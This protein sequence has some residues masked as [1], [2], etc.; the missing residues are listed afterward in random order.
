MH[1]L[2]LELNIPD[3]LL[4]KHRYDA[5]ED[6]WWWQDTVDNFAENTGQSINGLWLE[7]WEAELTTTPHHKR[8]YQVEFA[9]GRQGEYVYFPCSVR[10]LTTYITARGLEDRFPTLL[11]YHEHGQGSDI[12]FVT[13]HAHNSCNFY[14]EFTEYNTSWAWNGMDEATTE[15]MD[16]WL[17]AEA[18]AL[19]HVID[20][21][22][23]ALFDRLKADLEAEYD[24]LTSDEEVAYQLR[25]RYDLD[26]LF[27][28]IVDHGDI[29][30]F[31]A[32]HNPH[33]ETTHAAH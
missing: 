24:S 22:V 7:T 6:E 17:I 29:P 31:T 12:E 2:P 14:V 33:L 3:W 9:L 25:H 20:E 28:K 21:E 11:G 4:D 5:T 19:A 27:E 1:S 10:D 18:E 23:T 26:E 16:A 32:I 15:L 8:K 30:V 13:Q